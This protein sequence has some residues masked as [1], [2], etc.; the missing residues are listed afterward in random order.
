MRV[1]G[2]VSGPGR[3]ARGGVSAGKESEGWGEWAGKGG[4]SREGE[5]GVG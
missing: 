5:R 3:R 2:G 1:R 4:V